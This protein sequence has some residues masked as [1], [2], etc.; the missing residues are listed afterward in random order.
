MN[1][2]VK[3][4]SFKDIILT[5]LKIGTIG[6]G[7][8]I[9][10]IA[11]LHKYIVLDKKWISDDELTK[12]VVLGQMIPGPFIPNYVEYIGYRIRGIKGLFI[13]VI[14]FLFPGFLSMVILS[15]FYFHIRQT[16]VF[17]KIL[18]WIQPV[19]IGILIWASY[20]MSKLYWINYRGIFIGLIGALSTFLN[21]SPLI[22]IFICGLLGIIFFN[23][24]TKVFYVYFLSLLFLFSSSII[25]NTKKIF[26]LIILFFQLGTVIFG[27][28][29]ALIP[30]IIKEVTLIRGWLTSQEL[31]TGI[32]LSQITP[33]PVALI[34][35]FVGYKVAGIVGAF[36]A[37]ISIFLPS[38]IILILILI[39]NRY[40][41]KTRIAVLYP[42]V[43]AFVNGIKPAI[44]GILIATTITIAVDTNLFSTHHIILT[45]FK[46]SIVVTSFLL[47]LKKRLSP[48]WLILIGGIIGVLLTNFM[49]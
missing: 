44:V 34:A 22:T 14:A 30:F 31:L 47:L 19:I 23:N 17:N 20:D 13:S 18:I 41:K 25:I 29:Y 48:I 40:L 24:M 1:T 26:S 3:N 43:K 12:A 37:T 11:L 5:F 7:G 46:V 33:G 35:T 42:Y 16:I 27:G 45:I 21:I 28:G 4:I 36:F 8:G 10:T 2:N 39:L 49:A 9:G 32:A 15:F 6:F 38:T